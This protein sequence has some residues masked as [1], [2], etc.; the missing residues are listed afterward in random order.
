MVNSHFSKNLTF[1]LRTGLF[2]IWAFGGFSPATAQ[3]LIPHP[4]FES[5]TECP[6]DKDHYTL[7]Y[8]KGWFTKPWLTPEG[9]EM[10]HSPDYFHQC[11]KG[12]YGNPDNF[13]GYQHAS[14]GK[15]YTGIYVA[16]V[17]TREYMQA[18]L[19][20]PLEKGKHYWIQA[21]VSLADRCLIAIDQISALLHS[22]KQFKGEEPGAID[23]DA[24]MKPGISGQSLKDKK[25]WTPLSGCYQAKGGEKFLA[26]G[27]FRSD[28]DTPHH[29]VKK[30]SEKE[31][32]KRSYYYVDEVSV[33]PCKAA[34][35]CPCQVEFDSLLTQLD[36]S[37]KHSDSAAIRLQQIHFK[38]DE[39][40]L[41]PW[42]YPELNE[43]AEYVKNQSSLNVHIKGHTDDR[44]SDEHN[45]ELSKNRALVVKQYLQLQGV[46]DSQISYKG[47]GSTQP[48]AS[49]ENPSGRQKNRRVEILIFK[50]SD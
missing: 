19:D 1:L 39:A 18:K 20:T 9:Y 27:N 12:K 48:I 8:A 10:E 7:Q 15:A 4:S 43:I 5:H 21:N 37:L 31:G 24:A 13:M 26:L 41:L 36:E 16:K 47:F 34:E 38:T 11:N 44:G 29:W 49:N 25:D 28:E 33:Q 23:L 17:N 32:L 3:N 6:K 40:Q 45:Q 50:T 46:N 22:K 14:D 35:E 30:D 2:G 42:S